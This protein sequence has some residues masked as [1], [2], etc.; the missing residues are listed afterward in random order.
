MSLNY[1]NT[2]SLFSDIVCVQ[3][4]FLIDGKDKKHSNTNKIKKA[5][6]EHYDMFI[7]PAAKDTNQVTKGRGKGGLVTKM[8]KNLTKFVT[9]IDSSNYR[10]QATK[11][12][13][14]TGD[15]LLLNSYFPCDPQRET[16]DDTELINLLANIR[17]LI[18]TS[19]CSNILLAGDLNSDFNRQNRFTNSVAE[20]LESLGLIILWD[21]TDDNPSHLISK[22]DYTYMSFQGNITYCSTIDHF[23]ASTPVY[24][25]IKEAGVVHSGENLSQHSA[26][27]VKID[28]GN[29]EYDRTFRKKKK[30]VCWDKAT[31]EAK[32][33]FKNVLA[34][35]L[36]ELPHPNC[37]ACVDVTCKH[38]R[39]EI[40]EYTMQVLEAVSNAATKCLPFKSSNGGKPSKGTIPG[41]T[42]Y[43]KEYADENKFWTS[44]WIS[45]GKPRFGPTFEAMKQSKN[46]YSYAVRRLKR[47]N[48]IIQNDKFLSGI[49]TD[50][51][52]IFDEIRKFR[53]VNDAVSS[54][55]DD[56]VGSKSIADHF[57]TIYSDL[58]NKVENGERLDQIRNKIDAGINNHSLIQI[59]KVN[60]ELVSKALEKIKRS[61]RE[62]DREEGN[63]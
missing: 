31:D 13:F 55:I 45:E 30:L 54:R 44:I 19:N 18:L 35:T 51:K 46:Q 60:E 42:E 29:I 7:V 3:E 2:L 5:F 15:F 25:A 63:K 53:G 8:R 32:K 23:G 61:K 48:E 20:A 59:N 10:L 37:A 58:Y 34:D 57:S 22:V 43:V 1:L 33:R 24:K 6:G 14:P 27:Y 9:K 49:S 38:H 47:C 40:E 16:F 17:S 21:N 36:D 11:F 12:S 39:T 52:N 56:K 28:F 4:H 26:I 41:W 62:V 50:Q